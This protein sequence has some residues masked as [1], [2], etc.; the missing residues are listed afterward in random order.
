MTNNNPQNPQPLIIFTD[1]DGTLL[2]HHD[3]SF[4]AA[5]PALKA[6]RARHIPL[7][8]VTSK[9]DAEVRL[10]R[11][12]LGNTEP[13]IVE[14]G[15][16]VVIPAG[17][18]SI[19]PEE[20]L[21]N[22]SAIVRFSPPYQQLRDFLCHYREQHG[23]RCEGFGDWDAAGV[24]L[25]TGLPLEKAELARQRLG[26]EP[27]LWHDNEEAFQAFLQ[28][29]AEQGLRCVRG[30]RFIHLLGD[31]D[32]AKAIDALLTMYRNDKHM[33][34]KTAALGDSPND[35]QMLQKADI[36]VVVKK[37]DNTHLV[38][39]GQNR[40]IYTDNIGPAGWNHAVLTII[41]ETRG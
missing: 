16:A 29:A 3:Y 14:N 22:G 18:F 27:F 4:N 39:E 1:L 35:L 33:A 26:S 24:A 36:A 19:M 13:Y 6:L 34:P 5:L 11:A 23:C 7:I 32:K 15:C 10:L 8:P 17:Y 28:A 2:D 38:Y 31:A 37:H 40:V 12:E 30:G 20:K 9:T 21:D 41:N 25:Q